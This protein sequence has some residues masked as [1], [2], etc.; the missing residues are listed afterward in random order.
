MASAFVA[1]FAGVIGTL[2]DQEEFVPTHILEYEG[3]IVGSPLLGF[4][5][6]A[7][8]AGQC[9]MIVGGYVVRGVYLACGRAQAIRRQHGDFERIDPSQLTAVPVDISMPQRM[10][11]Q[12]PQPLIPQ[13]DETAA[14]SAIFFAT[15]GTPSEI[16]ERQSNV[17]LPEL[18]AQ[19]V[20][21]K[22]V[23]EKEALTVEKS[24]QL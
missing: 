6:K 9:L 15:Q 19:A 10:A 20:V 14:A 3:E 11:G 17:L 18:D 21:E 23:V 7:S 22:A 2:T 8:L 12:Q 4:G 24:E 16:S 5:C 1:A 13:S